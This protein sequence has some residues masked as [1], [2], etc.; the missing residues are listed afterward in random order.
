MSSQLLAEFMEQFRLHGFEPQFQSYFMQLKTKLLSSGD[1]AC[2]LVVLCAQEDDHSGSAHQ[3]LSLLLD[4]ARMGLENDNEY[5]EDFLETVE[6]AVQAGVAAGAVEQEN[7]MEFAGLYRRVGL[8]VPQVFM[9]DPDN[10]SLPPDMEDFD[11]SENLK[12]VAREIAAE[13][14]SAYDLFNNIDTMMAAVPEEIQAGLVNHIAA[15]DGPFF[16]RCAL[17]ALLSSSELVQEATLAGLFERLDASTLNAETLTLLPMIRSWFSSGPTQAALDELITKARRKAVPSQSRQIR[18]EIQEIVASIT[19]G[20][21]AQSI[22]VRLE[23][24]SKP[25]LAMV[26]IKAGHGIKDGFLVP[27]ENRKDAIHMIGQLRAET[28]SDD[29]SP[30][31][32]R[33]LLEGALA[34]GLEHG[35]L[36]APGFLDVIEACNLFDLRPQELDLSALLNL[37]DPE[38]KIQ[39]ASAQALGRWINDDIALNYLEPLTDSWFE[40]TEDTRNIIATARTAHSIETKLWKFLNTRRDIWAQRFLQT[41]VMLRDSDHPRE[42]R[43]LTSSAYGLMNGRVLKR[44]PLMEVIMYATIEADDAKMW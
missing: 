32:L 22:A 36:P 9:L 1:V 39:N 20:G 33:V 31:T 11:L 19:D 18:A 34:D 16:E 29:I 41:A 37:A 44:I 27:P 14:G 28:G 4:E 43:T 10:M 21:G 42:W 24:G 17:F 35:H 2:G 30:N 15:M 7:L 38:R 40:D 25:F 13:G 8:P 5:A 6:M 26:L 12:D 23:Q 3:I